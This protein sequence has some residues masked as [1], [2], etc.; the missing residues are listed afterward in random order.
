MKAEQLYFTACEK[1]YDNSPGF[2]VKAQSNGFE[3]YDVEEIKKL[4]TYIPPRDLPSQ[5]TN[6]EIISLFPIAFRYKK[7][8]EG[9]S[10]WIHSVYTGKD[11]AGERF[12]NYFMHGV[13]LDVPFSFWPIDLYTCEFWKKKDEN[14]AIEL[15]QIEMKN[16]LSDFDMPNIENINQDTLQQI[17]E[18]LIIS[19]SDDRKLVIR[20]KNMKEGIDILSMLLKAFPSKL[21]QEISF[22]SYQYDPGACLDIN[23]VTGETDFLFDSNERN[24]HFYVFDMIEN[25]NSDVPKTNN[26][27]SKEISYF[28]F[29]DLEKLRRYYTF[30]DYFSNIGFDE[31]EI[32]LSAFLFIE[33]DEKSIPQNS[34]QDIFSFISN[35]V[36]NNYIDYFINLLE[37]IIINII[38][39][40]KY[41]QLK[42]IILFYHNLFERT[43][44]IEY[45]SL[46][47]K[48]LVSLYYGTLEGLFDKDE[49]D[50]LKERIASSI[51][52]Y[53]KDFNEVLLQD[54][55]LVYCS[56]IVPSITNL[57]FQDLLESLVKA[58]KDDSLTS[59]LSEND[60]IV[61]LITAHMASKKNNFSEF[62]WNIIGYFSNPK[63]QSAILFIM[64]KELED[65]DENNYANFIDLALAIRELYPN[66][67]DDYYS[68]IGELCKYESC[69]V[70]LKYDFE[71]RIQNNLN[72]PHY[73]MEYKLNIFN[74]NTEF[75]IKNIEYYTNT[76][77]NSLIVG[78]K[79]K[80]AVMWAE[81]GEVEQFYNYAL[82]DEIWRY[83]NELLSFKP[84]DNESIKVGDLISR[85]SEKITQELKPNKSLLRDYILSESVNIDNIHEQIASL[86]SDDYLDFIKN[87]LSV[88]IKKVKTVVDY[89]DMI[90]NSLI[91]QY[92]SIYLEHYCNTYYED[93]GS[94]TRIETIAIKFWISVTQKDKSIYSIVREKMLLCLEDRLSTLENDELNRLSEIADMPPAQKRKLNDM[95]GRVKDK[96]Q[97]KIQKMTDS[98]KNTVKSISKF[99]RKN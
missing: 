24:F 15:T 91:S 54:E 82:I 38:H 65:L 40:K 23:I 81:T 69:W 67:S 73:F 10:F 2:Q 50:K 22:S 42:S 97:T 6:D 20:V 86:D 21:S 72:R 79:K 52:T 55:N 34:L 87:Y 75:N 5:P 70:I 57:M 4:G 59:N 58:F 51:P 61:E 28:L 18:A 45:T 95:L 76:Y 32:L 43:Q 93:Q 35:N 49:F 66:T 78:E 60:Y 94:L 90:K 36:K 53:Y 77:W 85:Y 8:N 13:L 89:G 27:Y 9:K 17:I 96:N 64:T 7:N 39:E 46:I 1:G 29:N 41:D 84:Y 99:W 33:G 14:D 12:G 71:N 62:P 19:R 88:K 44:N 31:L 74:K 26:K 56:G 11:Y 63:E 16:M 25:I 47:V 30:L 3:H 48:E 37:P 68:F 92:K 80:Q 83:L 98:M